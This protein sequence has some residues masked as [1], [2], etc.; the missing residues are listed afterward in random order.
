M[1]LGGNNNALCV[2]FLVLL[3]VLLF[4][5]GHIIFLIIDPTSVSSPPQVLTAEELHF[6]T[7]QNKVLQWSSGRVPTI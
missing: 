2:Y 6:P 7:F 4:S 1:Y 5:F 3:Q